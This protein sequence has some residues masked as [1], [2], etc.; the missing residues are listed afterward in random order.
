MNINLTAVALTVA[1]LGGIA[2]FDVIPGAGLYAGIVML[3]I[4]TGVL[5]GQLIMRNALFLLPTRP[6]AADG[7]AARLPNLGR[8]W[9]YSGRRSS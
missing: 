6:K 1:A 2:A 3:A 8:F 7:R 5:T 4:G 9:G